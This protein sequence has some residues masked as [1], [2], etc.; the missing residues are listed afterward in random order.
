MTKEFNDKISQ[1]LEDDGLYMLNMIDMYDSGRFLGA[2]VNTFQQTFPNVY[3][4]A[5]N[6]R[7]NTCSSFVVIATKREINIDTLC[8]QKEVKGLNLW[9]LSNSD[10][11]ILREK[12]C[13]TIL[14]DN[15]A[16]V[17]HLL[18]PALKTIVLK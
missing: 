15:Y 13:G 14:T 4:I 8:T 5:Q 18:A 9:V 7:H 6:V 3:V 16:P 10:M 1:I 2:I 11:E 17:E 12:A